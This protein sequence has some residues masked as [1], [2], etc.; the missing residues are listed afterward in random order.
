MIKLVAT[1]LLSFGVGVGG[2][3]A[4]VRVVATCPAPVV[5]QDEAPNNFFSRPDMPLTGHRGY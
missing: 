4:V 3:Y 1:A 2:T 5:A